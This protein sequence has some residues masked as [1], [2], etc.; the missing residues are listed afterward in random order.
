MKNDAKLTNIIKDKI[1]VEAG[2][3]AIGMGFGVLMSVNGYA[4]GWTALM[5]LLVFAGSMQYAAVGLL[6]GGASLLTFALTTLAV[7][8][9]HLFY[10]V[11]MIDKYKGTGIA[12][13][14][15]IF[16][17]TDETYALVCSKDRSKAGCKHRVE[18]LCLCLDIGSLSVAEL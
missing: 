3:L 17:L 16:G 12:K 18:C 2:Y 6:T 5:S 15:M 10:G 1:P 7:N 4:I 14:Y 13:P 11:S 8:A 9:R